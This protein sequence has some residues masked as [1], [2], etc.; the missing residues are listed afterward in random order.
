M[1]AGSHD[2]YFVVHCT[3]ETLMEVSLT[4]MTHF[5]LSSLF[6]Q[7][8]PVCMCTYINSVQAIYA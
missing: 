8:M 3:K 1:E 2:D 5:E 6:M 7:Y 4:L